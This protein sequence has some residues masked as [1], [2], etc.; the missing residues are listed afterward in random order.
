MSTNV[1]TI[2]GYRLTYSSDL[3]T[4][5]WNY[6]YTKPAGKA[7]HGGCGGISGRDFNK[8]TIR[9][10][11]MGVLTEAI[12]FDND[13][14]WSHEQEAAAKWET[15][16]SSGYQFKVYRHNPRCDDSWKY[17]IKLKTPPLTPHHS[18]TWT[19]FSTK[20]RSGAVSACYAGIRQRLKSGTLENTPMPH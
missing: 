9:D 15:H 19:G 18:N 12:T 3:N 1:I 4:M 6:E 11:M 7:G 2:G 17:I 14:E 5:C 13:L 10:Y 16:K 8:F 20:G